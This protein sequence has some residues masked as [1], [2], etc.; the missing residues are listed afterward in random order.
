MLTRVGDDLW[1]IEAGSPTEAQALAI[2]LRGAGNFLEVV[3]GIDSVV[4]RFDPATTDADG[5]RAAIETEIEK[6]VESLRSDADVIDIP[7][8]YDGPDLEEVC[9]RIG[10]SAKELI[11]LH[12]GTE[13]PV[14]MVGFT[15]GFA[16]IGG[17]DERL[18]IPRREEPRQR[19]PAG[20]V[21]IADGRTGLYA[22]ASPGGWSLIGRT[23]FK[24]FDPNADQPFA[25]APGARVRFRAVDE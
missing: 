23:S 22:M 15:P 12:T 8:V 7:V 13:F 18:K 14:D 21:G 17:L 16:F 4:A 3:P 25:L 2:Q 10:L 24:L 20:S 9:T 11:A 1:S 5:A 19:V 6:G